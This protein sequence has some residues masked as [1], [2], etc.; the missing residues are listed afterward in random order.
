MKIDLED[1]ELIEILDHIL[2]LTKKVG[3]SIEQST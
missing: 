2:E 1:Y 3:E